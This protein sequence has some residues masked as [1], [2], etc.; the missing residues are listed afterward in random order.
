M[1]KEAYLS[2]ELFRAFRDK[3]LGID[4]VETHAVCGEEGYTYSV[5]TYQTM[6]AWLREKGVLLWV[7]PTI[8]LPIKDKSTFYWVWDGKK[9]RH[10]A[11]PFG[12]KCSYD[13]YEEAVEAALK[14]V[15]ENLVGDGKDGEGTIGG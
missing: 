9:Q 10:D 3:G 14:Y 1:I 11:L 12:G 13:T 6:L 2:R 7:Y 8:H 4:D 5:P 15:L